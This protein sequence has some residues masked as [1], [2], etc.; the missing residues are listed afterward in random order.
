MSSTIHVYQDETLRLW[1]RREL[2]V[3]AWFD[4]PN[5]EQMREVGRA[6]RALAA[7]HVEGSALANV[8]VSGLPRFSDPVR[9]EGIR[10]ARE[11]TFR[12]GSCHVILAGG[13]AG[14]AARAF[15]SMVLLVGTRAI[16]KGAARAKVFGEVFEAS[17]WMA[18]LLGGEWTRFELADLFRE[19]AIAPKAS[20]AAGDERH[21]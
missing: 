15:M 20:V 1:S 7:Q 8:I 13:L 4:A 12:R 21:G 3:A 14:A 17:E 9:E 16:G 11:R 5:A 18:E 2:L 19:A 10:I 6:G